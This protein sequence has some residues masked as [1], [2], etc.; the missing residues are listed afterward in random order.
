MRRN[1]CDVGR[2]I[3]RQT[4]TLFTVKCLLVENKCLINGTLDITMSQGR[5]DTRIPRKQIV[6]AQR[7]AR[8]VLTWKYDTVD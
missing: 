5:I 6:E 1:R 7:E 4:F 2:T 3:D 8:I